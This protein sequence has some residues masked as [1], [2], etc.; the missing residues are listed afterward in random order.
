MPLKDS[1]E[2]ILMHEIVG[3]GVPTLLGEKGNAVQ[4]EK[5]SEKR[6]EIARKGK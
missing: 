4:K 6:H 1:P 5:L 2:L 3:Y